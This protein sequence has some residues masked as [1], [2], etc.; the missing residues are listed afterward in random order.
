MTLFD[1]ILLALATGT[2]TLTVTMSS[3][4]EPVREK[5]EL[6]PFFGALVNCG[7]CFAHW[8][9]VAALLLWLLDV[10]IVIY[11]LAL[12]SAGA[13]VWIVLVNLVNP[14]EAND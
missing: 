6:V 10:K 2:I 11:W 4:F 5:L 12:T 1:F 14:E 7:Y 8:A 9:A 13:F 3:I